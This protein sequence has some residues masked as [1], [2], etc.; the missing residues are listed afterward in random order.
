MV[1][2][3]GGWDCSVGGRGRPCVGEG[4]G[5]YVGALRIL[6]SHS[7]RWAQLCGAAGD[8]EG[9][10]GEVHTVVRVVHLVPDGRQLVCFRYKTCV[11]GR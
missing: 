7:G 6:C 9:E 11:A 3:E 8:L 5:K 1:Q 2:E 4:E 10:V